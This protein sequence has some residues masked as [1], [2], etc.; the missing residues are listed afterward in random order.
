MECISNIMKSAVKKRITTWTIK[1]AH[2]VTLR[3]FNLNHLFAY[4]FKLTRSVK[5][6]E[7]LL[8]VLK[9]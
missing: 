8:Q 2:S 7:R 6:T 1:M 3:C 4:T 5:V 9:K